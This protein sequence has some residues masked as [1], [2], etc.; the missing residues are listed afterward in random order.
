VFTLKKSEDQ[1][2]LK[3]V[4]LEI[5]HILADHS[6]LFALT[7]DTN[8]QAPPGRAPPKGVPNSPSTLVVIG[9]NPVFVQRAHLLTCSKFLGRTVDIV[10]DDDTLWTAGVHG[11]G[12]SSFDAL[13]LHDIVAKSVRNL[14]E[15]LVPPPRSLSVDQLVSN[16]RA[17]LERLTPA[18]AFAEL[19][20]D[21]MP[22]PVFL[23]DLRS[24]T[25]RR[26]EGVIRG[27][28]VIDRNEL[29]WRFDPRSPSRL[30]IVDRF[31]IRVILMSRAGGASSLAAYSLHQLGLIS[32]T[33]IIGGHV[34]WKKAGLPSDVN[35][36]TPSSTVTSYE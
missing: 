3:T 9:T 19:T 10:H 20:H 18:D 8:T 23:I 27:A 29:E 4:A 25:H 36:T 13:A 30:K 34:A 17:S 31:D 32:A 16:A 35:I 15:P 21:D 1:H 7:T 24:E 2:F 14:M 11:M 26:T 12:S 28:I 6:F 5:R 22:T 33:D